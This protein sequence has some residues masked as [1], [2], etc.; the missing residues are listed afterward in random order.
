VNLLKTLAESIAEFNEGRLKLDE[1]KNK[2]GAK[3]SKILFPKASLIDLKET[4]LKVYRKCGLQ[5]AE[6][7][8][9]GFGVSLLEDLPESKWQEFID[10]CEKEVLRES[11]PVD[12]TD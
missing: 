9:K 6:R 1:P 4:L 8:L 3:R 11:S 7:I 2:R 5:K 12:S 10:L